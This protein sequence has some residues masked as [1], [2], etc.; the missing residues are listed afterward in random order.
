MSNNNTQNI[1]KVFINSAPDA[2]SC[3]GGPRRGLLHLRDSDLMTDF[4]TMHSFLTQRQV[5]VGMCLVS[6]VSTTAQCVRAAS[7]AVLT[8]ASTP[9]FTRRSALAPPRP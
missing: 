6:W 2:C 7:S 5:S 3:R 1:C 9:S 4:H 8:S